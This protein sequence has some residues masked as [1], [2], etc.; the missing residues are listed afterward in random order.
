MT[1]F[2]IQ[3]V[4]MILDYST[5]FVIVNYGPLTLKNGVVKNINS[6][7]Y[8]LSTSDYAYVGSNGAVFDLNY[9]QLASSLS[10]L[11]NTITNITFDTVYAKR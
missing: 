7:A 4:D 6:N 9:I 3:D 2:D 10:T 5:M 11:T 8:A 1:D